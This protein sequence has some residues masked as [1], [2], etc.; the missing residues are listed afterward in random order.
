MNIKQGTR[1]LLLLCAIAAGSGVKAASFEGSN[2]SDPPPNGI[3][4]GAAKVYDDRALSIMLDQLNVQ[5]Q[6]LNAIDGSKLLAALEKQQG[7]G[8]RESATSVSLTTPL[9]PGV[10]TKK[11]LDDEGKLQVSEQTTTVAANTPAA[12]AAA[13]VAAAP[14]FAPA[15]GQSAEDTLSN[16]VNLT[17]QIY[18]VRMAL[19]RAVSDRTD[20]TNVR[21]QAVVAIPVSI[22]P[23]R[24]MHD[25]AAYVEVEMNAD[26]CISLVSMMPMEK[27]YNTSAL[28]TK[29]NAFGGSAVAS[30]LTLGVNHQ[31]KSQSMY[32]Y[33][34][35]DTMAMQF[36]AG[37]DKKAIAFGWTF[38]PVLGRRSVS[39][40]ARQMLAVVTLTDTTETQRRKRSILVDAPGASEASANVEITVKTYWRKYDRKR[41]T[42]HERIEHQENQGP[43]ELSVFRP[44]QILDLLSP[45]VNTL[46]WLPLGPSN[47]VASV[48]GENFFPG[49]QVMLGEKTLTDA[50]NG[51]LIK[52]ELLME[53]RGAMSD[54]ISGQAFISGRYGGSPLI[55]NVATGISGIAIN[56]LEFPI[57]GPESIVPLK[58]FLND[59]S[60]RPLDALPPESNLLITVGDQIAPPPY[61]LDRKSIGNNC[62]VVQSDGTVTATRCLEVTAM[63]PSTWLAKDVMI[64]AGFPFMGPAWRDGRLSYL[65][66]GDE[67]LILVGG[68]PIRLAL[69]GEDVDDG[70]TVRID[71]KYAKPDFVVGTGMVS[72]T[73]DEK[74]L[75]KFKRAIVVRPGGKTLI[76][77]LPATTPVEPDPTV[78]NLTIPTVTLGYSGAATLNG[79]RMDR[80]ATVEFEGVVLASQPVDKNKLV[81]YLTRKVTEKAGTLQLTLKTK[82][83]KLLPASIVV[84]AGT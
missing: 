21:T 29:A 31:S 13:T 12:P 51:L 9:T 54:L 58:L 79:T 20:G 60:S 64:G 59:R 66:G 68:S 61:D 41:L 42:M 62:D 23:P 65:N 6:S 10:L 40:G 16:Q 82:D 50:S 35:I 45:K 83:G 71:R 75:A 3:T 30:V 36:P 25:H 38:K 84:A 77:D 70:W 37:P 18:N 5:L 72:F 52:S 26:A 4:V 63:V 34:D 44:K 17:Y 7:Y 15:F 2:R 53:I 8:S 39:P 22:D 57:G 69:V 76:L 33:R 46:N 11:T 78:N 56:K 67:R 74:E 48:R 49:T 73:I 55:Q 32:L 43:F 80:I 27:T 81:V 47:F 28:S 14:A 19:E 24:G 1:Y